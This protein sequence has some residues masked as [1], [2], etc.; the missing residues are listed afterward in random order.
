MLQC[1]ECQ[2]MKWCALQS[3]VIKRISICNVTTGNLT[4]S[5]IFTAERLRLIASNFLSGFQ[6]KTCDH[7]PRECMPLWVFI[8]WV[9]ASLLSTV[10][11]ITTKFSFMRVIYI[12]SVWV[13]E[14]PSM[15]VTP[16]QCG[17][18]GKSVYS[19]TNFGVG[20][21]FRYPFIHIHS[22]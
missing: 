5:Y 12:L 18:V 15:R 10:S 20:R 19:C 2:I 1:G 21:K 22:S 16:A 8:M 9:Y 17:W 14:E 3:R 13:G 7:V 4:I 6:F 11:N